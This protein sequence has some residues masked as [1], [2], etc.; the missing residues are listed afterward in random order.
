MRAN[1]GKMDNNKDILAKYTW[2][3][4]YDKGHCL[5]FENLGEIVEPEAPLDVVVV[6][7]LR[8]DSRQSILWLVVDRHN[9]YDRKGSM[10]F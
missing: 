9:G 3:N 4:F 6:A 10:T 8:T 7:G 5:L 1:K 2:K